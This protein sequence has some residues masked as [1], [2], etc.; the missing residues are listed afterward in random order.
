MLTE[1]LAARE[2]RASIR[3]RL[4]KNQ[5]GSVSLNL[6]VPGLPKTGADYSR[7]FNRVKFELITWLL[8]NRLVLN[9]SEEVEVNH[10]AGNFY[11]IPVVSGFRL[12]EHLKTITELFEINHPLGRFIDVDV[13]NSEGQFISSG[14]SKV[15]FYCGQHPAIDCM[16]SKRHSLAELRHYQLR[17]IQ[18]YLTNQHLEELL[19]K[20]VSKAL[21]AILYEV[22]LTPKPGLVCPFSNGVHPD[23]DYRMFMDS[24]AV[25][26]SWF[27]ELFRQGANCADDELQGALPKIRTIGLQMEND[28]FAIT[29]GVNSQKGIIF[30]MGISL[31]SVGYVVQKT[32]A[33]NQQLFVE[34]VRMICRQLVERETAEINSHPQTHGELCF[35]KYSVGGVRHEAE[36]GFPTVFQHGLPVL[37]REKST[38]K[39]SLSQALL[40]IMAVLNDTNVLYRAG[41]DVLN[42]LKAL[43]YDA[44]NAFSEEKYQ[45]IIDF[46]LQHRISPGGSADLLGISVFIY[47]LKTEL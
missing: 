12:P 45:Q 29:S 28:M 31:F 40:A 9:R 19:R 25:I 2:E 38:G 37:E 43:C 3:D 23:M 30:L 21:R 16:R 13:T 14:K 36:Q 6:N 46:C 11:I 34:T 22:S 1:L 24:S 4:A 33:F 17:L 7:F 27:A 39:K 18:G 44:S 41:D 8:A 10:A 35:Q 20:V 15:C 5:S 32:G 47:L 42:Q 26:S